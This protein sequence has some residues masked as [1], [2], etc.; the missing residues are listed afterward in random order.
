MRFLVRVFALIACALAIFLLLTLGLTKLQM[1]NFNRNAVG[2]APPASMPL[3]VVDRDREGRPV[4]ARIIPYR[5]LASIPPPKLTRTFEANV[6]EERI[7]NDLIA[8]SYDHRPDASP[9]ISLRRPG[10]VRREDSPTGPVMRVEDTLDSDYMRVG[11]YQ[12]V[13]NHVVA[14]SYQHY[15]GPGLALMSA[16]LSAVLTCFALVAGGVVIAARRRSS[17]RVAE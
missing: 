4:D 14:T 13:G 8:S 16:A 7:I 1:K 5:Y 17:R 11:W 3:L 9:G 6:G 12:V 15:F 10:T 2:P